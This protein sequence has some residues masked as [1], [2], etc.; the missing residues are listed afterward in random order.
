MYIAEPLL[1]PSRG[2]VHHTVGSVGDTQVPAQ[3]REFSETLP[4]VTTELVAKVP[5]VG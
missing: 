3:H 1:G 5:V 4:P 2:D